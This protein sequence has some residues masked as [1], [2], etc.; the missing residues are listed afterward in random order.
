MMDLD[1][2]R[3]A[4][5]ALHSA[6]DDLD[7]VASDMLKPH[8]KRELGPVVHARIY[9]DSKAK[10]VSALAFLADVFGETGDPSGNGGAGPAEH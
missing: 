1:A 5:I 6:F 4:L 3:G 9:G 8:R 10:L 7:G 2:V